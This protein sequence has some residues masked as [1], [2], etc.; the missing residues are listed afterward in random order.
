MVAFGQTAMAENILDLAN[1]YGEN[2]VGFQ[3]VQQGLPG[4]FQREIAAAGVC[5]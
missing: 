4:G 2:A 1:A 5:G 3:R